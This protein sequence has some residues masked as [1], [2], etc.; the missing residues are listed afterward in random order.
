M[1]VMLK[2]SIQKMHAEASELRI[3]THKKMGIHYK[4][5]VFLHENIYLRLRK[6]LIKRL[7]SSPPYLCILC[8]AGT[9][10]RIENIIALL[11]EIRSCRRQR[12]AL[13]AA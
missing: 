6:L 8:V 7:N 13:A 5:V 12:S 9:L 4:N 10:V 2:Y 11:H 3:R 1:D